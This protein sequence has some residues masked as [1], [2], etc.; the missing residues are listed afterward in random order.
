MTPAAAKL[1]AWKKDPVRFVRE[2]L[3]GEPDKWQARALRAMAKDPAENP[4][5]LRRFAA[6]A[7]KGVGKS[8]L[9][10]WAIWWF[11]A[12][13]LHPKIVCT[14]ISGDNLRDG[15]WT[16]LAKWQAKSPFLQAAF[17]WNAERI[18][19]NDHPETWWCAARQWS[20]SAD[21]SQQ[22]LTLA[23]L[24]AENIMLVADEVGGIPD[25]VIAAAEAALATAVDGILLIC[26][27][28]THLSGPLYRACTTERHLWW[29]IEISS[30]PDDPER[31]TRVSVAWAREQI[32]K[33]GRDSPYVLVNVFGKFP[34][35]QSNALLGVEDVTAGTRR[36]IAEH[37]YMYSPKVLGVDVARF[38]DDRTVLF[39]R[40]GLLAMHP[41][42]FRNLDTM[43][44]VGQVT[45][46]ISRWKPDGI[47]VD[48]TG[49]GA[50]VVDR[51]RQLGH[52]VIGVESAAKPT[53]AEPRFANKRAEMW[54]GMAEWVKGGGCLPDV[55]EL[56]GD[57]TGPTYFFDKSGRLQLESKQDMKDRGLPSPDLAD[58]LALTFAFPVQHKALT[59][60]N[61]GHTVAIEYTPY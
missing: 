22:A 30:D 2:C 10:A 31:A 16:E 43:E 40:Q 27:N 35:A 32:E 28:P 34:P 15:L 41:K 20:K 44:V 9:E 29:V 48:Q 19:C 38:G 36:T 51:L 57:M 6:K 3:K 7:S 56:V 25:G 47:F 8:T 21:P 52:E 1:R 33:Y 39:P 26:G 45:L 5:S 18:V 11:L 59:Q 58:A 37:A 12:T 17:T 23:G 50:G 60:G 55:P 54:W 53:R 61:S 42:V 13:R 14:S 4:R 46:A 24:H 49:V